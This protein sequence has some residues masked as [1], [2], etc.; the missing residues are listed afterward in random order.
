M[1]SDSPE[2]QPAWEW[3]FGAIPQENPPPAEIWA[4]LS[5]EGELHRLLLHPALSIS[6]QF[7]EK[8]NKAM[9]PCECVRFSLHKAG[10][11]ECPEA[12]ENK[13]DSSRTNGMMFAGTKEQTLRA[14]ITPQKGFFFFFWATQ[15]SNSCSSAPELEERHQGTKQ[16]P[17]H[18]SLCQGKRKGL[19]FARAATA[20]SLPTLLDRKGLYFNL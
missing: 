16:C 4:E 19:I 9:R 5:R 14:E 7:P 2:P 18:N 20:H 11:Q 13:W 6:Q 1:D 12:K 17:Q 10:S 3:E 8:K 15:Q